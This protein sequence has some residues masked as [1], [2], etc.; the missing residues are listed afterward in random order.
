MRNRLKGSG[1]HIPSVW[2]FISNR[3]FL[4]TR[5]DFK[6]SSQVTVHAS[7]WQVF[8]EDAYD[9][10]E[11]SWP[12]D[13]GAFIL[14]LIIYVVASVLRTTPCYLIPGPKS[15]SFKIH[16]GNWVSNSG[17]KIYWNI[18]M[19]VYPRISHESFTIRRYV[20]LKTTW[21]VWRNLLSAS[22]NWAHNDHSHSHRSVIPML[23][24]KAAAITTIYTPYGISA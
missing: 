20:L 12:H 9:I 14:S 23:F 19:P 4:A 7:D 15:P 11:S 5:L 8:K 2:I 3:E 6:Y 17:I 24:L 22:V 1:F 16:T 10:Q 13:H 18:K 21:R